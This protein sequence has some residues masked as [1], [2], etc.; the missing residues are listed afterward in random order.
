MQLFVISLVLC[1]TLF[2]NLV[3]VEYFGK[4]LHPVPRT[5]SNK[6]QLPK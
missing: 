1:L 3:L 5:I 4:D 2:I 6:E